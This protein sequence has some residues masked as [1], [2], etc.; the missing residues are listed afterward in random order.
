MPSTIPVVPPASR[1]RAWW[2]ASLVCL[3]L[4]PAAIAWLDRPVS[5]AA[6]ALTHGNRWVILASDIPTPLFAL[7]APV[8][9]VSSAAY[10]W[11]RRLPGWALTLWLTSVAV[12]S[13]SFAKLALKFIFGRTWPETWVHNN[14][15]FIANGVFEFRLFAGGDAAYSA[16]PSGHLSLLLAC[17]TVIAVRHPRL[18]LLCALAIVLTAFGQVGA[19]FHWVSDVLAGA[20]LGIAVAQCV[21][22][23]HARWGQ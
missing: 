12:V 19:N 15:S 23:A 4:A 16:F 21:L 14:P 3:L 10:V 11:R 6:H 22:T 8:L 9:L 18:R 17:C 13:A 20:A 2:F 7:G 1:A 5:L